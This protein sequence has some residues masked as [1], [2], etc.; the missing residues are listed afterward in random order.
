MKLKRNLLSSIF[1]VGVIASTA[2]ALQTVSKSFTAVGSSAWLSVRTGETLSYSV[3]GTF[4]GTVHVERTRNGGLSWES[5]VN[6]ITSAASG[7]LLCETPNG[8]SASYRVR[9]STITSG[10]IVTSLTEV[11]DTFQSFASPGRAP[12]LTLKDESAAIAGATVGGPTGTFTTSICAPNVSGSTGTFTTYLSVPKVVVSSGVASV[13]LLL[14]T[15]TTVTPTAR[16]SVWGTGSSNVV[17]ISTNSSGSPAAVTVNNSGNLSAVN[18]AT[19]GTNLTNTLTVNGLF[20]LSS[21]AA[22]RSNVTPGRVGAIIV[23]TTVPEI[24]W[25]TGTAKSTWCVLGSS[26]TACSN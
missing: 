22:P 11:D 18:D 20:Q 16:L 21:D 4:A 17:S 15:Q 6:G 2:W 7:S 9:C 26:T 10:T 5:I 14:S 24:C 23:N 12:V 8:G 13:S 3:S 25:S 1:F 19:L